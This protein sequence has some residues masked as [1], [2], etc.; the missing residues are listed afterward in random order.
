MKTVRPE[1]ADPIA[2]EKPQGVAGIL[3]RFVVLLGA[4]ILVLLFAGAANPEIVST[5]K[6]RRETR[7][8]ARRAD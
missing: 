4:A 1:K 5:E 6:P 2:G 7:M 8:Q 3:V